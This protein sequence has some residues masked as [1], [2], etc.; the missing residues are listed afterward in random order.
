MGLVRNLAV[1]EILTQVV[2]GR[3]LARELGM[4]V[5]REVCFMGMGEPLDNAEAV[6]HAVAVL[7]DERRFG[8]SGGRVTVSTV[9]P[10]P[11]K[12]GLLAQTSCCCSWSLHAAQD[13]LRRKL[14]PCSYP[15][16]ELRDALLEAVLR[17][18]VHTTKALKLN[19]TA[20]L[21]EG[22][23]DGHEHAEQLGEFLRPLVS[24]AKVS[25]LR[26][27]LLNLIPYNTTGR[28]DSFRRPSAD[29][30]QSFASSAQCSCPGLR[31]YVRHPRGDDLMAACGQ[32]AVARAR[33]A[34]LP[35]AGDLAALISE[36]ELA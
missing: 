8:F 24:A 10:S 15:A 18:Q 22:V 17:R 34:D 7:T 29:R 16:A 19:I 12:L 5:L 25:G 20:T 31:V 9:G 28:C 1:D 2:H 4:P 30:V 27:V 23:N 36:R 14:L 33:G 3:R 21:I 26:A 11:E 35:A 13:E 6:L 32:L